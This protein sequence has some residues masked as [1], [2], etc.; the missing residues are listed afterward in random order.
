MYV[1]IIAPCF[2]CSLDDDGRRKQLA[3]AIVEEFR[4]LLEFWLE[5]NE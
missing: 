3:Y 1:Q 2:S 4:Q 5:E